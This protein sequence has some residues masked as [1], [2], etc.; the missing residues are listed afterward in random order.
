MPLNQHLHFLLR[1]A[2]S[3]C[4]LTSA[5][6]FHRYSNTS[7]S[8][9]YIKKGF[10]ESV[11]NNVVL[12]MIGLLC[13]S[14]VALWVPRKWSQWVAQLGSIVLLLEALAQTV[15]PPEAI[16]GWNLPCHA[17]RYLLPVSLLLLQLKHKKAALKLLAVATGITFFGHGMKALLEEMIF[18]DYLLAFFSDIGQPLELVTGVM[19]LHVI[20]TIDI[21]LAHHICFFRWKR[22]KWIL[23]YTALWGAVTAFARITYGGWSAWHEVT[24][25][26]PHFLV[27]LTLLLYV[28]RK[29]QPKHDEE[30]SPVLN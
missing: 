17:L 11:G 28:S 8:W 14:T 25:R 20:G 15:Y 2:A 27:P 12:V 16:A 29:K 21:A 22:I 30:K 23:R 13:L 3:S 1:T 9:L 19:L 7:F 5:W 6:Q 10:S 24:L 18:L 26:A 4:L